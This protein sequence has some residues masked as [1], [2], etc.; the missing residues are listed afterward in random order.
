MTSWRPSSWAAPSDSLSRRAAS[1]ALAALRAI[2]T[3]PKVTA[4]TA[5]L[6]P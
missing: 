2:D 3:A 6:K 5:A 1:L 4:V